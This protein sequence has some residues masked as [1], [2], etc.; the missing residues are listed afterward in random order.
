MNHQDII[1]VEDQI[2]IP[3]HMEHVL[4]SHP[5][6]QEAVIF[7]ISQTHDRSFESKQ[8]TNG[9]HSSSQKIQAYIVKA[10][11]SSL[12]AR[13]V[14]NFLAEQAPAMK[15]LLSGGVVFLDSIPKTTVSLE[16]PRGT[17]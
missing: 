7:G 8:T 13:D 15:G 4:L 9:D 14:E 1:R 17:T 10:N 12:T 11:G 2:I 16:L 3:I 6:I 5:D